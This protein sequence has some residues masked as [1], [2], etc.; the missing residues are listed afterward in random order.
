MVKLLSFL[1]LF[2]LT[3]CS[4]QKFNPFADAD[5]SPDKVIQNF[6]LGDDII[7]K[8]STEKKEIPTTTV[9]EAK[10]IS[11]SNKTKKIKKIIKDKTVEKKNSKKIIV[12]DYVKPTKLIYPE[13]YP[14]VFKKYD[15]E[16]KKLWA[17]TKTLNPVGE[18]TF[19]DINYMGVVVGKIAI[20]IKPIVK[21]AGEDAYHYYAKL[22]S[23]PFYKYVYSLDDVI[24]SFVRVKDNLP[25]KYS[26]IQRESKQSIDD[27]Q[28][29]DR[30]KLM[31]YFRLRKVK[32]GKKS[33]KKIDTLIPL[34]SQDALS[35]I[36]M[37]RSLPLKTGD[38][39]NVPI[40]T[41]GKITLMKMEVLGIETI[42]TK[43]GKKKAFKINAITQYSGDL[44]RKGS[45]VYWISADSD[46][47][48][49]QF[50]AKI[51]LGSVSG[52]IVSY[53]K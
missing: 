6:D 32:R 36:F 22:K 17:R 19:L 41:R 33:F 23:A 8:F 31:T 2:S 1:L 3:S 46:R 10:K 12:E 26:L 30:D 42:S 40:V 7:N 49:L 48:F 21:I 47:I 15:V 9:V 53:E 50:K 29:F 16:S 14:E 24:E 51:K 45:M 20:T 25:L 11:T 27:I 28:L 4:W 37:L 43:I 44:V 13:G 34:Y 38:K 39:Y 18:K 5:T 52:D 35:A